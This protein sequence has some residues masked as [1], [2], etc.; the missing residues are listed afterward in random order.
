MGV[1]KT[2]YKDRKGRTKEAAAW[3]VEFRDHLD[4]VRRL[5]AFPSKA[6]SEEMGRGLEKLVAVP[7]GE[8]RP[9]RPGPDPLPGGPARADAGEAGCH[10]AAGAR[11]VPRS[12]PLADHLADFAAA[13]TAKGNSPFH[14]EVVSGRARRLLVDGC[15][16]RFH[17]DISASKVMERPCTPAGRHPAKK[18]GI[19][20]QTFNFY[21]Q[22]VKQFCKWMVK[23]RRA[24]EPAG[25]P[26]RAERED[27]P[28]A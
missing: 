23:D 4:T 2:T 3:Y 8:R 18:R 28:P 20:A 13:L 25:P 6:A 1:F 12:K 9:V 7:Q 14:V 19:S 11:S 10:R 21:L 15:G 26:R 5:P 24:S 22:S 17:G 16:F 27:R